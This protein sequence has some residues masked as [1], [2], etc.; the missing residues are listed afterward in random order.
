MTDME[1]KTTYSIDWAELTRQLAL[2]DPMP[3]AAPARRLS[4]IGCR[5]A[6][7]AAAAMS[8]RIIASMAS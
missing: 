4:M 1:V 5:C 2:R 7:A 6:V 3:S 8:K